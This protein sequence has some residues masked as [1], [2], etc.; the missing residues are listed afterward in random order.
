[1]PISWGGARGVN[2]GTNGSP[3]ERLGMCFVCVC[4]SFFR[5]AEP[6]SPPRHPLSLG[7]ILRR[8]VADGGW[9]QMTEQG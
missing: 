9:I 3:M 8:A 1:M 4:V 6:M 5:T 2:V 7:R